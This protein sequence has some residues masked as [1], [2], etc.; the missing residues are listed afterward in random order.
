MFSI[1][2][3]HYCMHISND[4]SRKIHF[5]NLGQNL[6]KIQITT[7]DSGSFF[8]LSIDTY[9]PTQ[10]VQYS[11]LKAFLVIFLIFISSKLQ[12]TKKTQQILLHIS[13]TL[14]LQW[15]LPN[16]RH[17]FLIDNNIDSIHL[18]GHVQTMFKKCQVAVK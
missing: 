17:Y 1:F 2:G 9:L 7:Y 10:K 11:P 13:Q 8:Y 6:H 12:Q 16:L 5:F 3:S 15:K 4:Y 18:R 14:F